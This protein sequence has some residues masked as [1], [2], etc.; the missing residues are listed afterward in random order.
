ML[1]YSL[2]CVLIKY[3]IHLYTCVDIEPVGASMYSLETAEELGEERGDF[4]SGLLLDS[5]NEAVNTAAIDSRS[6]SIAATSPTYNPTSPARGPT[7]RA[8]RR[9]TSP[10]Y[11]PTSPAYSPTSPAYSSTSL[12]YS[13][14]SP[15]HTATLPA[16]LS[17]AS[18]HS[19]HS[20]GEAAAFEIDECLIERKCSSQ[21]M[22]SDDMY[23]D[24]GE[25]SLGLL[26]GY[27]DLEEDFTVKS[28]AVFTYTL[29]NVEIVSD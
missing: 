9:H 2:W 24:G 4:D 3:S 16:I 25:E 12:A 23:G 13:P 14:T 19:L 22:N 26:S 10:A 5:D 8:Y 21:E 17:E 6:Q 15:S 28:G 1:L 11:S 20:E 27:L 18:V 29:Y 7:F